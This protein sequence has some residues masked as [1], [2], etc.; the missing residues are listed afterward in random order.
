MKHY[1]VRLSFVDRRMGP[2]TGTS[3]RTGGS[4]INVA[5][6]RAVRMFWKTLT[7]KQRFDVKT[8]GLT[9]FAKE[10]EDDTQT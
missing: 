10:V 1:N 8:S 5:I 4:S 9:I 6:A 2:G 7:Q 3:L